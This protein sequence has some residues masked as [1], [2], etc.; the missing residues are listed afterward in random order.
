MTNRRAASLAAL[1]LGLACAT[2]F[3]S[4]DP[5]IG[6]VSAPGDAGLGAAL[7]T[8]RSLYRGAGTRNDLLP[9]YIYEGKRF[10]LHSYR[11]GLKLDSSDKHRFD[12]FLSHR[13]E[14]FPFDRVPAT[15]AGMADREPG[16]DVGASYEY[17]GGWGALYGAAMRDVT[18]S[19]GS[20]FRLGYRYDWRSGRLT[21]RPQ[22]EL[23]WRD[24]KL[25]NYYYGVR[26]GEATALRPA[27]EPG[28][29]TNLQLGLYGTYAITKGWRMLAG[30]STTR[31][32]SGVRGSP[33]VEGK[34]QN[35]LMLGVLYDFAPD[36]EAWPEKRPLLVRALA[37]RATDCDVAK[38]ARLACTSTRTQDQTRIT[39]VE[40]GRP[41]VEG[42]AGWPL[43]L[44][45]YVGLLHHDDRGVQPASWQVNAY[46]KG[47][48]YGFPWR[49]RVMTRIGLGVGLSY[50]NRVPL[51]EARDQQRN[52]RNTSKLLNYLD[53]TID[54]SLG[55]LLGAPKMKHVFL[56]LGVSHRSGIFGSSQLLGNVNG[57][58]NYI[59]SYLEMEM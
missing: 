8:E 29:G 36:H 18:A 45:G 23:A 12:V 41:F 16:L 13:F 14:G 37:G 38:V 49:E 19:K 2:A 15:L 32:S 26:P 24:S 10:Y 35:S 52:G 44:V 57:G 21:L 5:L 40:L 11:L 6:V 48:F 17:R 53:P 27:Y 25:N 50:A 34:A 59:Y 4:T 7:R 54:V 28:G 33:I 3:A 47:L 1:A 39:A 30:F 20:E 42:V 46:M 56:G 31:W 58:S 51:I 22:V 9:L 55:D 43:D